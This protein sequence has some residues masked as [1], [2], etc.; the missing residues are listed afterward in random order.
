[1]YSDKKNILELVAL[2]IKHEIKQ[3]VVCPGS[4]NSPIVHTLV[5]HPYFTCYAITDERSAAFFALGRALHGGNPVA[6]CCTSG[7]AVLNMHPAVAEAFYQQVPL[8]V[9]SADRPQ[10]W[11]GQMD[12][13]TLPQPGVF[14]TLVKKSVN[15]PEVQTDEDLW[16][17]NRLINE[18]ILELN[19]HGKGPVH[20]NI[21]LSEPLF[22]FKTKELPE[23]R[24]ITRYQGLNVYERDYDD[25]IARLNSYNRRLMVVGQMTLIYLFDKRY[26]KQLY[27]HFAWFTEHL[28]NRTIPGQPIKNFDAL[29][30]SLTPEQQEKLR[31]ELVITYGGHVVSK[32]IRK[33]LR[34]HKPKEHWHVS[35]DG[36]VAD[37]FGALTTVIEMD[38]FEFLERIAG[39]M[40]NKPTQY[41]VMWEQLSKTIPEPE[42]PY[43]EAAAVGKL[44]KSLPEESALHLANSSVV[45]YAQLYS[46]P[47]SIEVCGNRGTSGIDGSLST[48]LGYASASSKP[49]FI[50]IGDLSF[51]YDMNALWM[52]HIGS[53]V[54]IFLLNNGGGEI[55]QT[56]AGLEMKE[57]THRAVTGAHATSAKGWAQERGFTYL[58]ASNAEE[59]DEAMPLFTHLEQSERPILLEVFTDREV[60][61]KVY[62]EYFNKLRG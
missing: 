15:L 26:N 7:T 51:F 36:E 41:P 39:L 37:L 4:R 34:T 54:R 47:E 46:I 52:G 12:G 44:L 25:L 14:G 50:L 53:N 42:L 56:L 30:F 28:G 10:A 22:R 9:I 59:L 16:Y 57:Q 2:L 45:R 3:I 60:G 18:A 17:C 58:A 5:S 48:A 24:V 8:L 33:Y 62:K 6:V 21:P 23:V 11:I 32:G 49:N 13:Q 20:I 27:K 31:P 35:R 19:H 38:P 1:M 29:L 40:D 43:S 55:F 61:V